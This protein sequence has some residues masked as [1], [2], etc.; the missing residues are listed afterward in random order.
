MTVQGCCAVV[1]T[2]SGVEGRA[3]VTRFTHPK[4]YKIAQ[5]PNTFPLPFY[6]KLYLGLDKLKKR[7]GGD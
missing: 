7:K 3:A 1:V 6:S 4:T 5:Q 2:Q